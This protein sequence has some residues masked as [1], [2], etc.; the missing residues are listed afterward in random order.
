MSVS[1]DCEHLEGR[2]R[3]LCIFL[4]FSAILGVAYVFVYVSALVHISLNR[5]N[6]HLLAV[7]SIGQP[8]LRWAIL[9]CIQKFQRRDLAKFS[10]LNYEST[11]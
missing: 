2:E 3:A 10:N 5:W 1:L 4:V 7:F 11:P 8:R 6:W 9:E